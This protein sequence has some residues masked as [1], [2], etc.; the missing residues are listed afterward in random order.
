[1]IPTSARCRQADCL[2]CPRHCTLCPAA[3]GQPDALLARLA[4]GGGLY[5]D[6]MLRAR[7]NERAGA[8]REY[9]ARQADLGRRLAALECRG[10]DGEVVA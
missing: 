5:L 9:P 8:R 4:L 6:F 7:A 10:I 3:P 1:M 2:Q